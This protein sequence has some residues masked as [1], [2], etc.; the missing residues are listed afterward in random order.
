MPSKPLKLLP[1]R[2]GRP[3]KFGRPSR[4]VTVTLP[5]DIIDALSDLDDDLSRAVVRLAQPLT[6]H[7]PHP[8]AELKKYG[9]SAVII[10]RPF[11]A[12]TR[13]PGVT[14]VPLPDGR[15]LISLDE[16]LSIQEFELR[17][18]DAVEDLEGLERGEHAALKAIRDILRSA[19]QTKGLTVHQRSIIVLQSTRHRRIAE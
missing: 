3:Q 5:E 7:V 2:R 1:A 15:A 14:L 6:E 12:L 10:V 18:R 13:I 9:D 11:G 19:R 8:A 4:A 16:T 17:I